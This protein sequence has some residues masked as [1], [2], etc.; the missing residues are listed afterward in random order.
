MSGSWHRGNAAEDGR[1]TR[2]W[3][4]GHFVNPAGHI[5]SSKDV[6]VKWAVHPAGDKRARWTAGDQRTTLTLLVSGSFRV[7]LTAG[8][9]TLERQGDYLVWGAGTDH[10]W[11]AL[12]DAV[13]ITVRWPSTPP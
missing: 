5:R 10:C 7:D 11:E 8:S 1:E 13:V 2:G 4:L 9:V 12:T 3:I 6:E